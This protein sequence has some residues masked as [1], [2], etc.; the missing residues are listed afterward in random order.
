MVLA[1]TG[2]LDELRALGTE[3]N[4]KTYARHGITAEIYGVSYANLYKLQKRI[5]VDHALARELW[6]SGVHDARILATM[7]ADPQQTDA[8]MIDAWSQDL[9]NYVIT[10]ALAGFVAR[11]GPAH[12]QMAEWLQADDEWLCTAGWS[13]LGQLALH[14]RTL[15][16]A[17]FAPYLTRIERDLHGSKNR[18]RHAMNNA[19]IAIGV[20][21]AELEQQAI[22]V[23]GR[24][25]KVKVD[26]GATSCK[27]PDA[28]PYIQKARARKR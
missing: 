2:V 11:T 1:S 6:A 25:G 7:I 14:D 16:D 24:I 15:P 27:T 28:I 8:A 22:E 13:L 21:N 26:H 10:D 20:R 4:R 17:F 9:G 23:A 19:L 12:A 18:V 5:K 3:Q